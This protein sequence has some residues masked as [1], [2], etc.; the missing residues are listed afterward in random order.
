MSHLE[1]GNGRVLFWIIFTLLIVAAGIFVWPFIN[2]ILIAGVLSVLLYPTYAK[3]N[4][5][6]SANS[7]SLLVTLGAV[8]VV[9]VPLVTASVIGGAQAYEKLNAFVNERGNG[10]SEGVAQVIFTEVDKHLKPV[11]ASVGVKDFHLQKYWE[12]NKGELQT[13]A[14]APLAKLGKD[15]VVGIVTVVIALLT[16]FF[17]LR[18]GKSLI[19]PL[20]EVIPLPR[21]ETIAILL[22]MASTIRAVFLGIVLVSIL[23]GLMAGITYWA[24]GIPGAFLWML[25]TIVVCMIPLLGGP[26]MY[27]PLAIYLFATDQP[28]KAFV[29]LGVGLGI[30][31]QIDNLLRP[32]VIGANAKLHPMA[33]FFSLLGGVLAM[34]PIGLMAGPIV[35]TIILGF[36]DVL[37][38]RR[39]LIDEMEALPEPA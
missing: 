35:L 15:I 33:V 32:F 2:A 26:V 9:L 12:E 37:R 17:M 5:R 31:S 24:L 23:Q 28:V 16:M 11:L 27:F 3:L 6:M 39:R 30:I 36:I 21:E 19:N 22:K 1:E 20:C 38:T 34:G 4:Q 7:A 18:D 14:R 10:S 8:A 25:L 13:A 29:L